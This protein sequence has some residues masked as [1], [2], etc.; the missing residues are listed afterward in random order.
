MK[1]PA[2]PSFCISSLRSLEC[3]GFQIALDRRNLRL[4][5]TQSSPWRRQYSSHTPMAVLYRFE[6]PWQRSWIWMAHWGYYPHRSQLILTL[7]V[8]CCFK[9]LCY[10]VFAVFSA[11][12]SVLVEP[13]SDL[14]KSFTCSHS[15]YLLIRDLQEDCNEPF[16]HGEMIIFV[17]IPFW[18]SIH[19]YNWRHH[20]FVS[21]N[22]SCKSVAVLRSHNG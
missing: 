8:L 20:D 1:L 14:Y 5:N 11:A 7:N 2:S 21:I 4:A 19:I 15:C 12:D 13:I 10:L 9:V 16:S 3:Q 18:C 17:N 22:F 6:C